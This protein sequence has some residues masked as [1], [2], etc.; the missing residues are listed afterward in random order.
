MGKDTHQIQNWAGQFG[1]EYTDR[2]PQTL[3][4]MEDSYIDKYG[5]SRTELNEQFLNTIVVL[6]KSMH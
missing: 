6:V 2:N 3:K 1:K 5:I 4:E